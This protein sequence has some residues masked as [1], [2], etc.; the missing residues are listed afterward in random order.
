LC[1]P[2]RGV[3]D[4]SGI[5]PPNIEVFIGFR[6]NVAARFTAPTL[7][8]LSLGSDTLPSFGVDGASPNTRLLILNMLDGRK[9]PVSVQ[10][11]K[12]AAEGK[13]RGNGGR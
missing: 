13:V 2:G 9:M 12:S 3:I 8:S 10:K 4:L 7:G 11:K 1:D 5:I 6:S